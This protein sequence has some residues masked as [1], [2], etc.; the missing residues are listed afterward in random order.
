M[1]E[2]DGF[3]NDDSSMVECN[4][5]DEDK[6]EGNTP[7]MQVILENEMDVED[8]DEKEEDISTMQRAISSLP[9]PNPIP[10]CNLR[11]GVEAKGLR[12]LGN[13][14][15]MNASL[16]VLFSLPHFLQDL[17][18]L[19]SDIKS[20]I[21]DASA[22]SSIPICSALLAIGKDLG[23]IP[24]IESTTSSPANPSVLKNEIEKKLPTFLGNDQQDAEE[25]MSGLIAI[26]HGEL[27]DATQN[28]GI[29]EKSLPTSTFFR[30]EIKSSRK[31][32]SCGSS[33]S[34]F[35]NFNCLALEVHDRDMS[36]N[37][38]NIEKSLEQYFSS[39]KIENF[40]CEV[41]NDSI[42]CTMYTTVVSRPR[43]ILVQLKRFAYENNQMRKRSEKVAPTKVISLENYI[44]QQQTGETASSFM[45]GLTGV[46]FH[47]GTTPFSGHYIADALRRSANSQEKEWVNFNDE[48]AAKSS[49]ELVNSTR[50]QS[51]NYMLLYNIAASSS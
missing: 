49:F 34:R 8:Y 37:E 10:Q 13:T 35:Q 11:Q 2:I 24:G 6:E 39:E 18:K 43:A 21:T 47:K 51:E 14:C 22:E 5:T 48:F 9:I 45:Y 40:K 28:I 19:Y 15:Y 26:L 32:D 31:C 17:D 30:L 38:W 33:R 7:N 12:N 1:D 44:D 4:E 50:S 3:D 16:Q 29:E 25:F 41:C 42:S 20:R 46:V 23:L 36:D 27:K